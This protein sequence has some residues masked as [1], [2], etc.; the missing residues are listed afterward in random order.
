MR[1]SALPIRLP[2]RFGLIGFNVDHEPAARAVPVCLPAQLVP[3][4]YAALMAQRHVQLLGRSVD[5]QM[6]L[7]QQLNGCVRFGPNPGHELIHA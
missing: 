6:L 1:P 3:A 2:C 7:T 4:R 5:L